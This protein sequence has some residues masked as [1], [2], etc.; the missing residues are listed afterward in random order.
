MVLRRWLQLTNARRKYAPIGW[1]TG[2]ALAALIASASVA[3]QPAYAQIQGEDGKSYSE[4]DGVLCRIPGQVRKLGRKI[5]FVGA[6][7]LI[8]TRAHIC[9]LRGGEIIGGAT[10]FGGP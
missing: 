3:I 5:T 9:K 10:V 8:E 6:K 7:R 2:I 1:I 4:N